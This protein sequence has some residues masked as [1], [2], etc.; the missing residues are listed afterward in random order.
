MP[1]YV[2][3]TEEVKRI[4]NELTKAAEEIV[5]SAQEYAS[6]IDGDLSEWDSAAKSSFTT[7]NQAQIATTGV[8][9]EYTSKLGE[10]IQKAAEEITKL[11]ENL[12]SN[13]KI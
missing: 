2:C 9:A 7:V 13:I 12:A 11:D 8:D 3:D 4:G 5:T 1:K 10:F 6:K